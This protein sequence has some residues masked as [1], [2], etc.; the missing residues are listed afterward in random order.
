MSGKAERILPRHRC[1]PELLRAV[2]AAGALPRKSIRARFG[3]RRLSAALAGGELAAPWPGV[4]VPAES[5]HEP[6]TRALAA[7]TWGAPGAVLSGPTALAVHGCAPVPSETHIT[8]FHDRRPP[9]GS[10]LVVRQSRV[11]E[12]EVV[13]LDGLRTQVLDVALAEVLCTAGD[14]TFASACLRRALSALTPAA[15]EQLGELVR[16]R[17]AARADR[18]GTRR[19]LALLRSDHRAGTV[20]GGGADQRHGPRLVQGRVRS[21]ST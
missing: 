14:A 16:G 2:R 11:R 12:S 4:L 8:V 19:A 21:F 17:V 13:E 1:D 6:R 20:L 9:R 5:L 18:R 3:Q 15:A 7:L 10:R